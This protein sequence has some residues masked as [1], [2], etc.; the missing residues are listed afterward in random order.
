M[1]TRFARD[2]DPSIARSPRLYQSYYNQSSTNI[3]IVS[4]SGLPYGFHPNINGTVAVWFDVAMSEERAKE[5]LDYLKEG[6]FLSGSMNSEPSAVKVQILTYNGNTE[7]FGYLKVDGEFT[8]DGSIQVKPSVQ[9]F[10]VD[11]YYPTKSNQDRLHLEILFIFLLCF[12]LLMELKEFINKTCKSLSLSCQKQRNRA[13]FCSRTIKPCLKATIAYWTQD[14]WNVLDSVT[15]AL[16]FTQIFWWM[17]FVSQILPTFAPESSRW[18]YQSLFTN[19][20]FLRLHHDKVNFTNVTAMRMQNMDL[21]SSSMMNIPIVDN[22]NIQMPTPFMV[23]GLWNNSNTTVI[24]SDSRAIL[25]GGYQYEA[26][27]KLGWSSELNK[28]M[29]D[30]DDA[31]LITTYRSE[32]DSLIIIIILCQ[33]LRLLK[34]L[35]FQPKLALV[36]KTVLNAGWELFHF[37]LVF[38]MQTMAFSAGAHIAFGSIHLKFATYGDSISTCFNLFLGDTS[39][40]DD[41]SQS[42]RAMGWYLF[43]LTYMLL[44]FFILLN[45]L[46]A[47]LVDA[48]IAVRS[49]ATLSSDVMSEIIDLILYYLT[50]FTSPGSF[51]SDRFLADEIDVLL[52]AHYSHSEMQFDRMG[53]YGKDPNLSE[54][55][56]DARARD[57]WNPAM[58]TKVMPATNVSKHQ[59]KLKKVSNTTMVIKQDIMVPKIVDGEPMLFAADRT[60]LTRAIKQIKEKEKALLKNGRIDQLKKSSKL[61]KALAGKGKHGIAQLLDALFDRL[62][63]D[64]ETTKNGLSDMSDDNSET[65]VHLG[66]VNELLGLDWSKAPTSIASTAQDNSNATPPNQPRAHAPAPQVPPTTPREVIVPMREGPPIHTS[67]RRTASGTD[68]RPTLEL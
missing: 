22:E 63:V 17:W 50:Y 14:L 47:I 60:F 5:V 2:S 36:T 40:H 37:V 6:F 12:D 25:N 54:E 56:I 16:L 52:Q 24:P 28:I 27:F 8:N 33:V 48:Y 67:T 11:A 34:V 26:L 66:E 29:K 45:I 20:R 58:S 13:G 10:G 59:K 49:S 30:F 68:G 39:T 38:G 1:R 51:I 3:D 53:N 18:V 9:I 31:E 21:D 62:G 43:F 61:S 32:L 15:L 19:A 4:F 23:R 7:T 55:E 41:L 57:A 65:N 44:Q 42:D 64:R 35:D 46:L